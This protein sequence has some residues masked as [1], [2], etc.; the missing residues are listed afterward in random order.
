MYRIET[1]I[2]IEASP[3][4]VWA[5]LL[6]WAAYPE[7]NPFVVSLRGE[8]M[9]G[10][11]LEARLQRPGHRPM[12]VKP[13]VRVLDP[14]RHFAWL[15]RLGLPRLFDGEH[16]FVLEAI[17]GG[18]RVVQYEEFRGV[19]VPLLRRSLGTTVDGFELMNQALEERV[20]AQ[21]RA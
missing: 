9:V 12:T 19:A 13:R 17:D 5:V 16:H 4:E 15:G 3:E 10:A 7:W 6:D 21:V 1:S 2:D 8:P 18:T 20:E 14:H 11:R